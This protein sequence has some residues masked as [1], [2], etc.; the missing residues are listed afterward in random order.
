MLLDAVIGF[1]QVLEAGNAGPLTDRYREY[2]QDITSSGNH[3]LHII[4][5]VLD[6]AKIGAG[7]LTLVEN[8]ITIANEI[9][10]NMRLVR[11]KAA[12]SG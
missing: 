5:D 1:S 6:L 9:N 2:F 11:E 4:G 8:E 12:Q 7:K 10:S 3:L